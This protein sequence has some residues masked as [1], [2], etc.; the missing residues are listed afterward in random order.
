[1]KLWVGREK[2]GKFTGTKTL[3]VGTDKVTFSEIEK[4]WYDDDVENVYFGAGGCTTPNYDVIRKCHVKNINGLILEVSIDKLKFVPKDIISKVELI[5]TIITPY[6]K[7]LKKC[8]FDNMQIKF[9]TKGR[10]K[11]IC[12]IELEEAVWT[13]MNQLRGKK[14]L[15]DKVIR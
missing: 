7:H 9:E 12:L 3:F 1:M 2:E 5:V 10:Q 13:N 11:A 14:Y 8:D 15:G 4:V 6:T